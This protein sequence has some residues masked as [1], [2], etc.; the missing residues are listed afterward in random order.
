[1]LKKLY[2]KSELV[3]AIVW[4]VAYVIFASIGDNLSA[5][6]GI[7]KVVTLPILTALTAVIILF[8]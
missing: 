8:S 1:M 2:D 4:I 7:S 5:S 6:V 3:F